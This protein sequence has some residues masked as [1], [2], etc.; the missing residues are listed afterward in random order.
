MSSTSELMDEVSL[1]HSYQ[2]LFQVTG[3]L[4]SLVLRTED[5]WQKHNQCHRS[6]RGSQSGVPLLTLNVPFQG[7]ARQCGI[8]VFRLYSTPSPVTEDRNVDL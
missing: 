6:W 2:E 5:M 7:F 8:Q 1:T 4:Q 3:T